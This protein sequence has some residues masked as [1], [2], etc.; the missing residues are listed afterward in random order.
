[1]NK[2]RYGG[3][4]V[5]L[6]MALAFVCVSSL[7]AHAEAAKKK[8]RFGIQTP[9]EVADPEDLIKLWQEA[10]SWGYDTAWTFDHFIP[11]SGDTK[12]P[13]LDGWMLL[14]ALA[15]K[16]S[17]IRIGCLVTGNT[18]RNPAILAKMAT[19]VDLLSHGRLELGIGAGWFEFE[20]TAYDIPF[21][22]PKERTRRLDEAIRIIRSLWTEKETTFTGKYYQIKNAPFEPKPLQKPYPPILIGGVGKK[23][24]LPIIAKYANAWNMLPTPPAQMAELLKTLDGYCEKYKRDCAEIEKSYLARLVISEDPQKIDQAVQTLAQMRKVSPEEARAMSLVGTPEEVKK[25]VQA[26][27]DAGVT[28]IIIGQRQ[29]YDRE[30]LQRFAKEV[31]PAFR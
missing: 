28:H 11:I 24:T 31:M 7:S 30:G 10:E 12:G 1:M 6:G 18:Y 4:L 19:T 3:W 8:I 17:K 13:C 23:W 5:V 15:E 20:H 2:D 25:Q 26:Y 9:P 16:T 14:G 29:P 27:I 21:Y 22:T